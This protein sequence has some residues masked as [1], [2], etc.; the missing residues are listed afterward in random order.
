[1]QLVRILYTYRYCILQLSRRASRRRANGRNSD[2]RHPL[3]KVRA[4]IDIDVRSCHVRI[5]PRGQKCHHRTHFVR[6]SRPGQMSGM[7]EVFGDSIH[8]PVRICAVDAHR[9]RPA[10]QRL[11]GDAAR[12]H[13]VDQNLVL[14]QVAASRSSRER[15]M[16]AMRA[17]SSA[18]QRADASPI[19]RP[20]PTSTAVAFVSPRSM[21]NTRLPFAC[22]PAYQ[23][24]YDRYYSIR[25]GWRHGCVTA[26]QPAT[27]GRFESTGTA[28]PE[29]PAQC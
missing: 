28:K 25:R 11:G 5:A 15:A 27:A 8:Q 2:P 21:A 20:P 24:A 17:P 29:R 13:D 1:V 14:G 6:Q 9:L 23:K 3:G 12:R 10:D 26:D 16:I 18:R 22:R 19:P 7:P 4:T